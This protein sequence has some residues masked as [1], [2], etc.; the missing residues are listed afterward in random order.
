MIQ[1]IIPRYNT[2]FLP[3]LWE[4]YLLLNL[5]PAYIAINFMNEGLGGP[6]SRSRSTIQIVYIDLYFSFKKTLIDSCLG[7]F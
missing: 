3:F 1:F 5:P 4:L 7:Y 6:R 2:G